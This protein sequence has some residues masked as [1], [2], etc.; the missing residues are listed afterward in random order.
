VGAVLLFFFYDCFSVSHLL[1]YSSCGPFVISVESF[2][3]V[4]LLILVDA[5]SSLLLIL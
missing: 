5:A 2:F 4:L 3:F 1:L